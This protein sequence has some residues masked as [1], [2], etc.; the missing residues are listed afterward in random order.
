MQISRVSRRA[1]WKLLGAVRG[2]EGT[3]G[4]PPSARREPSGD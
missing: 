1:L 4:P 2:E 3:G